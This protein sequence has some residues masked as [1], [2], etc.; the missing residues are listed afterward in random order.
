MKK[1]LILATLFLPFTAFAQ[2]KNIPDYLQSVSVSIKT[3]N[4]EG[5][6][7]IFTRKDAKG[8]NVSFVVTAAHVV[9]DA[10][11][12]REVLTPQG[13]KKSLVEFK[14]PLVVK[15]LFDNGR[16]VGR[17]EIEAEVVK[18][19]DADFGEDLSILKVT[20]KGFATDTAVLNAEKIVPIGTEV[21]HVGSMRG[22]FGYNSLTTGIISSIGRV[23]GNKQVF[24]Q[25][26]ATANFGSSGCGIYLKSDG[27]Y[28][29]Q[30]QRTGGAGFFLVKPNRVI[31]EWAKVQKVEWVFDPA[32]NYPNDEELRKLP[33]EDVK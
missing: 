7:V 33:I 6:G 30:V 9:D 28:V 23:I 26:S 24:D 14:N 22:E 27:T 2:Q 17:I 21:Y 5:S 29:G 8:E 20:Q 31:R 13:T 10:R 25:T 12:V 1:L 32:A 18:Y 11:S 15:H 3:D 4:S 16:K 19:S